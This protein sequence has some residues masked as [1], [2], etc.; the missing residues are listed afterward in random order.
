VQ[1]LADE[2]GVE[3]D[4]ENDKA[5][6]QGAAGDDAETRGA[7]SGYDRAE[8]AYDATT[9]LEGAGHETL[10]QVIPQEDETLPASRKHYGIVTLRSSDGEEYE[11]GI[12]SPD[13]ARQI[14]N[15]FN[16]VADEMSRRRA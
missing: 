13:T 9:K 7:V 11:F 3:A 6:D 2:A 10:T 1:D 16:A 5:S 12:T 14:A 4:G 8:E 15:S